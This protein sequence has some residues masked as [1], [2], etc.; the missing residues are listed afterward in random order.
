MKI[1]GIPLQRPTFGELTVSAILATGLWMAAVGVLTRTTGGVG[2]VEAGSL[3]VV[4]AW[5][6]LAARLG[7]RMDRGLRH[8]TANLVVGGALLLAY[9]A[10]VSIG[11]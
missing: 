10:C 1:L 7:I 6:C 8:V 2:A 5:G 9:Q 3:L 4:V 11:A